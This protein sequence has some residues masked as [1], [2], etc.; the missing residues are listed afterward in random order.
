MVGMI[1]KSPCIGDKQY[2]RLFSSERFELTVWR[3]I[4]IRQR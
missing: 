1:E 2:R 4:L 3:K